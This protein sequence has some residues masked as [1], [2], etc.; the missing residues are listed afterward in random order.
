MTA[1]SVADRLVAAFAL[2]ACGIGLQIMR[3]RARLLGGLL[4]VRRSSG[5]GT[6][7]RSVLPRCGDSIT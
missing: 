1:W 4:D 2:I 3:Y 6:I 5:G 7:V